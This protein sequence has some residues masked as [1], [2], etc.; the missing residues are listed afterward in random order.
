[1][2]FQHSGKAKMGENLPGKEQR[3]S[4]KPDVYKRQGLRITATA[5]DGV[6]EAIEADRPAFT[7]GVQWHPEC[8]PEKKE[9]LEL[10]RFFVH[11]T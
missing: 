10:F 4:T 1:M 6:I 2:C 7:A 8:M 11:A 5:S 3:E 9:M